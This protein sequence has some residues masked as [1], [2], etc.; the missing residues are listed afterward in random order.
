MSF[1]ESTTCKITVQDQR[2]ANLIKVAFVIIVW[3]K[4]N[5]D[6][7]IVYA[8]MFVY[9]SLVP[10]PSHSHANIYVWL[11]FI[12][13]KSGKVWSIWWCNDDVTWTWFGGMSGM[14]TIL[15]LLAVSSTMRG[16]ESRLAG[17]FSWLSHL[18]WLAS[19]SCIVQSHM[20]K[21]NQILNAL[22]TDH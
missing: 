5:G 11:F 12:T 2:F 17:S 13:P 18:N 19:G 3:V 14:W 15:H 4:T 7:A 6:H 22:W 8:A 21:T 10:R 9:H 1:L 16:I 20:C